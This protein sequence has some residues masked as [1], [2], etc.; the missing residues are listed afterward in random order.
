M[1]QD[2]TMRLGSLIAATAFVA[3]VA[4]SQNQPATPELFGPGAI[5][6][7]DA[8]ESF[9]SLSPSGLDFYFTQH[10]PNFGQH[11]IVVSHL[12]DGRWSRPEPT[13]FSSTWN[14]REPRLSPDGRRLYFSSNR[15]AVAG[16]PPGKLD[17][18][19]T[20]RGADGAWT[21]PERLAPPINT[22]VNDFCPVVVADGTLFFISGR[23]GGIRGT[24]PTDI[25]NVWRAQALDKSGLRFKE[26]ENLGKA[27]NTGLE[28]N[29]FVTPDERTMVISR[30]GAP[31]GLGGDDLYVSTR[32]NNTWQSPL[33]LPAPV[34]SDK[35]EYGPSLTADGKWLIFTSA[36]A[37]TTDIYRISAS[38]LGAK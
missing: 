12:R 21:A 8:Y 13:P 9:G 32:V 15:P 30:D 24:E 2:I 25:Y 14:D 10:Q 1:Q 28:T 20:E 18:F 34:N 33:H 38:V 26:P 29:V 22:D 27:I 3:G 16:N 4:A 37:G 35:Y 5:S 31:D 36:R 11:H 19:M 7:P 6:T 17:L 23:P